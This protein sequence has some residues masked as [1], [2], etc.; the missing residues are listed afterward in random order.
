M[1]DR[2]RLT[3]KD[4]SPERRP[5]G[6]RDALWSWLGIFS[7]MAIVGW[8]A[9][10]SLK[11]QPLLMVSSFAATLALLYARP[12]SPLAQPRNVIGGSLLSALIGVLC[13]Q[14]L[15]EGWE[16]AALAIACALLAM[17]ATRTLHPPGGIVA[18]LAVTGP[19]EL[20]ELGWRYALTPIA[21]GCLVMLVVAALIN[22]RAR[23][24]VYPRR[25]W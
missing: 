11:T 25:W 20:H 15:G 12:E 18:L 3:M 14:W 16:T 21:S 24:R 9:D 1:L 6:W 2:H 4:T 23:G 8:L 13:W 7:S 10:L 5:P 19:P 22:T 17:Q